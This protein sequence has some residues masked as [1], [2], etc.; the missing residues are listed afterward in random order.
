VLVRRDQALALFDALLVQGSNVLTCRRREIEDLSERALG[1][2]IAAEAGADDPGQRIVAA[3]LA[4]VHRVLFAEGTRCVLAGR[5]RDEVRLALAAAARSAFDLLE[6]S[7][8]GYGVKP[9]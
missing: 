5:P 2:I 9:A 6:P 7:L 8:G 1:D 3:Q 4:A